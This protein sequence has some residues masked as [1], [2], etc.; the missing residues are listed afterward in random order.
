MTT[1]G[2]GKFT[3]EWVEGWGKLPE[4]WPKLGQCGVVT[5]SQDR[6]YCFNR[7]DH[8]LVVFDS[9]GNFLTSWGEGYLIDSHGMH[10]DADDNLYLPVKDGHVVLKYDTQGNELMRLGTW[11][12]PSDTGIPHGHGP[13]QPGWKGEPYPG[14]TQM[15][16]GAHEAGPFNMPTDISQATNGDLY[17]SDGYSNFRIHVFTSDGQLKFSWGTFGKSGPGEFHTP[18][19]I[20]V[21]NK[22]GH[23]YVA[24]RENDR[25][26]IFDMEGNYINHWTGL[27]RPCTVYIDD[28]DNIFVPELRAFITILDLKGN[29]QARLPSPYGPWP[30]GTAAHFLWLD[31]KGNIYINQHLDGQQDKPFFESASRLIKYRKV[32]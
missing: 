28:D 24:D 6:V 32:S 7:S 18:H 13:G 12:E 5:D 30:Y 15:Y 2:H 27:R 19:G 10:V 17:I 3:Y 23:V 16:P 31:S 4:G 22:R 29:V 20:W 26:Q 11:N 1:I 25:I 9:D 8:P 14:P 21:D